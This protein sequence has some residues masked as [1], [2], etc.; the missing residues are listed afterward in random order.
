MNTIWFTPQVKT[1][2]L[3]SSVVCLERL[4]E[5]MFLTLVF[6]HALPGCH[7]RTPNIV[8]AKWCAA[9][10]GA[11]PPHSQ[12][13]L[14]G[15]GVRW[16]SGNK[17]DVKGQDLKLKKHHCN[18]IKYNELGFAFHFQTPFPSA[19]FEVSLTSIKSMRQSFLLSMRIQG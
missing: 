13:V 2:S 3:L 6:Q 19:S 8:S 1:I 15:I 18:I 16:V 17:T 4:S 10:S 14:D 7:P 11:S 5:A 12:E 9:D